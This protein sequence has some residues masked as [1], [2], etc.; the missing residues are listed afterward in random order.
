MNVSKQSITIRPAIVDDAPG[1][2]R[3][4][5]DSWRSTYR[6]IV[7]DSVLDSLDYGSRTEIWQ[8]QIA[9]TTRRQ[10]VL[11]AESNASTIVGFVSGGTERTGDYLEFSGEIYALYVDDAWQGAG[12]GRRL[13]ERG[14]RILLDQGHRS[15]LIWALTENPSC[16]FYRR[17]GGVEIARQTVEMGRAILEETAFGWENIA[18][19]LEHNEHV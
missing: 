12:I 16:G 14:M 6:G 18:V 3:A 9:D 13:L 8:Q 5:I 2:A 7:P 10:F 15:M 19:L 11:V 17:L 1:I 4:H